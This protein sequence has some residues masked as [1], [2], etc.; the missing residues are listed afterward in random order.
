MTSS[1][2]SVLTL[3]LK[4]VLPAVR[5]L[6]FRAFSDANELARWWGPAGFT[7]PSLDFDPRPGAAY[8]IE[9]QPPEG[10]S[11]HLTGEFR[12]VDPPARLAYTFV[13]EPP[14]PDDVETEV[15]L[16]FRERGEAT[17]VELTQGPFRTEE[18]L[19]LHRD[20]WTESLDK[21]E[22]VVSRR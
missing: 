2:A 3:E 7:A 18:R 19:A 21:L 20:G 15:R 1:D 4:R 5:S 10:D 11:F 12:E 9:M 22:R 6:V 13:W 14:D 16:S 8:R 17:E